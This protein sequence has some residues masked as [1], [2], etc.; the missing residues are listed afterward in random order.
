MEL[1]QTEEDTTTLCLICGNILKEP[2]ECTSCRKA[3][4]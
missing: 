1:K 3:F 2:V 4:C